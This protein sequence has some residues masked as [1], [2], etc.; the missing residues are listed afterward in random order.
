MGIALI[1]FLGELLFSLIIHIPFFLAIFTRKYG[2][3]IAGVRMPPLQGKVYKWEAFASNSLGHQL[4]YICH[5]QKAAVLF[6]TPP[7][8]S[9]IP[10]IT[11]HTSSHYISVPYSVAVSIYN[12]FILPYIFGDLP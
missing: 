4:F 10:S 7:S 6:N 9:G 2:V 11:Y 1:L 12:L 5:H 8:L 3:L